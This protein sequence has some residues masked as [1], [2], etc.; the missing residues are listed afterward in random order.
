MKIATVNWFL[1]SWP[2]CVKSGN[3]R[4]WYLQRAPGM[5]GKLSSLLPM[6]SAIC[7]RG[8]RRYLVPIRLI[9]E[10]SIRDDR[11]RD[12]QSRFSE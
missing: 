6:F 8:V 10:E 12:G 4:D 11:L 1:P 3:A 5:G 9:S 7:F 2:L